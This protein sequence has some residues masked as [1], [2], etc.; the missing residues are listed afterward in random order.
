[1]PCNQKGV[2]DLNASE[3]EVSGGP[4]DFATYCCRSDLTTLEECQNAGEEYTS[5]GSDDD[6]GTCWLEG[7]CQSWK[8][9]EAG[10]PGDN[11]SLIH[12]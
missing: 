7:V 4:K 11:L 1:M 5:T 8:R 9:N 6:D 12:I 2:K 3:S 10:R